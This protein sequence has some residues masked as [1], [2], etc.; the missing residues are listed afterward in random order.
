VDRAK[1]QC[2]GGLVNKV[3]EGALQRQ[4]S[5]G[6]G[7]GGLDGADAIAAQ[8]VRAGG[9]LVSIVSSPHA[10]RLEDTCLVLRGA[11]AVVAAGVTGP[12]EVR[13]EDRAAS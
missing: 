1:R 2:G 9:G 10:V 11:Q 6:E 12:S 4:D 5:G 8:C 3:E 7:A 13:E